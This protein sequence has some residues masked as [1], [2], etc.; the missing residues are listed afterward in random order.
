MRFPDFLKCK[1]NPTKNDN[2]NKSIQKDFDALKNWQPKD[3]GLLTARE[4][5]QFI[6][7]Q[8]KLTM[9]LF[10]R[11]HNDIKKLSKSSKILEILTGTLIVLTVVLAG[12]T[13]Y[14]RLYPI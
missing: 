5:Q 13:I 10:E 6:I 1:K 4:S 8:M 7:D 3:G 14:E 2:S 11:Q 12:I 9:S